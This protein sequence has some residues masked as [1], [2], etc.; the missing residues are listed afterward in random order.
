MRNVHRTQALDLAA[1][2]SPTVSATPVMLEIP[3]IALLVP[4]AHFR[5]YKDHRHAS[6]VRQALIPTP[7]AHHRRALAPPAPQVRSPRKEVITQATVFVSPGILVTGS[8][9][10]HAKRVPSSRI[11]AVNRANCARRESTREKLALIYLPTVKHV[12]SRQLPW[13]GAGF[14]KTARATWATTVQTGRNVKDVFQANIKI[15]RV[16]EHAQIAR[17]TL[18]R[19]QQQ[20]QCG[21]VNVMRD[22]MVMMDCHAVN[23]LR[24]VTRSLWVRMPAPSV[25]QTPTLSP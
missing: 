14:A 25:E 23:A 8:P 9:A 18:N 11:R 13:R 16:R 5:P 1:N 12:L 3:V 21:L 4:R 22:I 19:Y 2:P 7:Q 24:E 15:G 17:Q 6:N 20:F 10:V